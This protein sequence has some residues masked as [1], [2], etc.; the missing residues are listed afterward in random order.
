MKISQ[1]DFGSF[2]TYSPYGTTDV[3]KRS[4]TTRSVLK[5]EGFVNVGSE[6]IPMSD[7]L[8]GL[9]KRKLD[10]LPFASFFNKNTVFIPAPVVLYYNQILFGFQNFLQTHW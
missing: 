10:T 4:R 7:Y 3:E 9:I 6:Q 5:E 8:A 2:L 1:I